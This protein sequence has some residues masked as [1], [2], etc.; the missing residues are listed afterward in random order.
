[1]IKNL[2]QRVLFLTQNPM[3]FPRKGRKRKE[4]NLT[5]RRWAITV[6]TNTSSLS[7]FCFGRKRTLKC[8]VPLLLVKESQE[9]RDTSL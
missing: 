2:P 1:M 8:N 9:K 6:N 4:K 5:Q 7:G 3:K